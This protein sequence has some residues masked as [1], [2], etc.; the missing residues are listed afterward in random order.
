M[1]V[2]FN[3][4]VRMFHKSYRLFLKFF[5]F[6]CMP[7]FDRTVVGVIKVNPG[8]IDE[9]WWH[10]FDYSQKPSCI[11]I[12]KAN[13]LFVHKFFDHSLSY[14][15]L[16]QNWNNV[17]EHH[18]ESMEHASVDGKGARNRNCNISFIL[19]V[20]L[21]QWWDVVINGPFWSSI[22]GVVSSSRSKAEHRWYN[23]QMTTFELWLKCMNHP[24]WGKI[25]D[26]QN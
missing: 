7:I 3:I 2:F 6:S 9:L 10:H 13:F 8:P 18:L 14:I 22:C 19:L 1:I 15:N 16:I 4:Y 26:F 21:S 5:H 11:L 17:F 24:N 23:S 20:L 25:V 12:D